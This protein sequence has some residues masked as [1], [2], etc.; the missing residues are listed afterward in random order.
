MQQSLHGILKWLDQALTFATILAGLLL[1]LKIFAFQQVNVVGQ[2][3]EPNFHQDQKLLINKIEKKLRRGEVVSVYETAEMA[4]DSN[5]LTKTFPTFAGKPVKFLL[6]RVI[7]LPGDEVEMIGSKVVIYNSEFP[8]GKVL[9]EGY[10]PQE[11]KDAMERG[12][13]AY[14]RYYPKTKIE[15]DTYFLMG[16]NR[17]NS[18]D[19][20]DKRL[21]PFHIS[22]LLGGIF[23]RYWPVAESGSLPIGSYEWRQVDPLTQSQLEEA[24]KLLL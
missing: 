3:M 6:K 20:R 10:L 19:S 15:S 24:K 4:K 7:A 22:M 1:L 17:C 11:T 16:D 21:G 2:S 9:E 13:P 12:C 23:Y 5:F 14:S 8:N 18:F